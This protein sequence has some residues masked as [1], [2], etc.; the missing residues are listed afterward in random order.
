[1]EV[2]IL[3][4]QKISVYENWKSYLRDIAKN[5]LQTNLS[6]FMVFI[7]LIFEKKHEKFVLATFQCVLDIATRLLHLFRIHIFV[8]QSTI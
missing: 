7:T 4:G 2:T 3:V 1:M 5:F 6:S 8:S